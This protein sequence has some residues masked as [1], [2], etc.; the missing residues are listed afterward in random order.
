MMNPSDMPDN[1]YLHLEAN[2]VLEENYNFLDDQQF[3]PSEISDLTMTGFDHPMLASEDQNTSQIA[4]GSS[5][6]YAYK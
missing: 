5:D 3:D 2:E 1:S 4:F 6:I